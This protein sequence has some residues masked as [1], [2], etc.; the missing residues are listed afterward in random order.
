LKKMFICRIIDNSA[1]HEL[2]LIFRSFWALFIACV[3]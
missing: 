2:P 1:N 3:D